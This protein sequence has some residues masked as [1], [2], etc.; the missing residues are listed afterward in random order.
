MGVWT[1][2]PVL[3]STDSSPMC[4]GP[5]A[6]ATDRAGAIRV[7]SDPR[8]WPTS[9]GNGRPSGLATTVSRFGHSYLKMSANELVSMIIARLSRS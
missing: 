6:I 8:S 2:V 4:E 5:G 9:A 1:P 7:A 3:L